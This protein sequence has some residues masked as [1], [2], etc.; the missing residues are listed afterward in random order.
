MA[1]A[2]VFGAAGVA[3]LSGR[4]IGGLAADRIGAKRMIVLGL[5]LQAVQ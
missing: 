3:W 2:T 1:A 4:V 5:A